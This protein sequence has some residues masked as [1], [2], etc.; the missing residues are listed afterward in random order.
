MYFSQNGRRNILF[1]KF[2]SH[3]QFL[4]IAIIQRNRFRNGTK[5][6]TV[7]KLLRFIVTLKGRYVIE[8]KIL[9]AQ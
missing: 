4:I 6:M 2:N 9:L 1:Y 8:K 5:T 7:K 3:I